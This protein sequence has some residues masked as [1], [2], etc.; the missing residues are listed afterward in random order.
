MCSSDLVGPKTGD[1]VLCGL[2]QVVG[3]QDAVTEQVVDVDLAPLC[4][5]A[6]GEPPCDLVGRLGIEVGDVNPLAEWGTRL[7][8]IVGR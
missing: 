8:G 5:D 3:L 1:D 7:A 6:P 4:L 2:I